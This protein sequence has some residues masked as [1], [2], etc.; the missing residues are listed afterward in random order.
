MVLL[1][2]QLSTSAAAGGYVVGHVGKPDGDTPGGGCGGQGH[3]G[4]PGDD[5]LGRVGSHGC[6][7]LHLSM[8]RSCF[9]CAV[10]LQTPNHKDGPA[11][12]LDHGAQRAVGKW[13][14]P[15]QLVLER[16]H[17]WVILSIHDHYP[18]P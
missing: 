18:E 1:K 13:I 9:P 2:L 15:H 6:P 12:I 8:Q 5:E 14:D 4:R 11:G 17:E 16:R 3:V 10:D 7:S